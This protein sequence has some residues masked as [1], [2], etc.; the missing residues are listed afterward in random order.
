VIIH[1]NMIG[2]TADGLTEAEFNDPTGRWVVRA[3][4]SNR[5][6]GGTTTL[7]IREAL[8]PDQLESWVLYLNEV[9]R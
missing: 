9:T 6:T 4:I 3:A 2:T 8:T 1:A 7:V 5:A